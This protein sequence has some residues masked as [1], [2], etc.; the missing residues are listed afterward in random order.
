MTD[1]TEHQSDGVPVRVPV[2]LGDGRYR[3][4]LTP[5]G[6]GT[7][8][9]DDYLLT[10]WADDPCLDEHGL[11]LVIRALDGGRPWSACGTPMAVS[12]RVTVVPDGVQLDSAEGALEA[13]VTVRVFDCAEQRTLRLR[14]RGTTPLVLEVTA[15]CDVVLNPPDAQE[16]HPAFSKL[17]VQTAWDAQ[18]QGLVALRRPRQNGEQHPALAL[19]LQGAPI[20]SYE[21]DRARWLGRGRSAAQAQGLWAALSNTTGSVLDPV[22]ALRVRIS[23]P[24]QGEAVL[25]ATLGAADTRADLSAALRAEGPIASARAA[26]ADTLPPVLQGRITGTLAARAVAGAGAPGSTPVGAGSVTRPVNGYG[27]FVQSGEYR[28]VLTRTADGTLDLPPMPWTNVLANEQDFGVLVSE[29]GALTTF[30]GNSRL[31]RLTPWRNDPLVDPHDEAFFLRDEDSGAY[32]SLLPGPAPGAAAYE[33]RHG[34]GYTTYRHESLGLQIEATVYVPMDAPVRVL[35]VQLSNSS[36]GPRRLALYQM[37]TLV[38][39]G[40][41]TETRAAI[42]V[43]IDP[44][45]A[46]VLATNAMAG[47]FAGRVLFSTMVGVTISDASIDR[48]VVLGC[49]GSR[50]APAAVVLGGPLAVGQ[51]GEAMAAQRALVTIGPGET[52]ECAML[53]GEVASLAALDALRLRFCRVGVAAGL[54]AV[55]QYWSQLLSATRI[56]TPVPALDQVMNGWLGYQTLVCRLWARSAYYQSGGAYGFRDQLQDA[57]SFALAHPTLLRAQILRNAAHQFEAGDVLHWWHPP[58]S[59]GIRTRFADDLLWL[60]HLTA[61]YLASTGDLAVLDELVGFRAGPTLAADEDERYFASALAPTTATVYEHCVRALRRAMTTGRHGLPLFGCGDWN[62]GMNR[63]GRLGRGESTWMGF[64]L[65]ATMD[66]FAPYAKA[67]GDVALLDEMAAYR[68]PLVV[69]LNEAGW[70][71]GWY[72]RG[73]YDSGAPLG[74]KESDECQIDALAQAWAVISGVAS[75]ERTTLA[76]DALLAQLVSFDEGLVRLLAPPFVNTPE[77]PG[78]IKG[79]VAGVRE[80]G[81]Q[82]THAALWAAKALLLAG[83][84]DEGARLLTL[85]SPVSHAE[86]PA[87]V[88]RYQVEPYVIAADIYG[89]APHVGRGG[90]TWY[91]GSAGWMVRVTLENLLG[92]MVE[93]GQ[94]LVIAP[95]IPDTWPG[96]TVVLRR[97]EG[98][99][100]TIRVVTEGGASIVQAATL[101]GVAVQ[102]EPGRVVVPLCGDGAAHTIEVR[103]GAGAAQGS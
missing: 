19:C 83:R 73:Y 80:N 92:V 88:A 12:R 49:P 6:S 48:R 91:T 95:C 44:A 53:L 68:A 13:R 45:R 50:A 5:T 31:H 21:T 78:Y 67:R 100:Y 87:A 97:E 20:V 46:C 42:A 76:L 34:F 57:S 26:D 22:L 81:G 32:A 59:V 98:T 71:G 29:K 23:L 43:T 30:N 103:L 79:Y 65:I 2:I 3:A 28:I 72:R 93:Q 58:T 18:H 24:A 101:D 75:P 40:T 86:T 84:R 14:N 27:E 39:G 60:P 4:L 89:V 56:T 99:M 16:G 47:P 90:W 74:S 51:A 96:Y 8:V 41:P 66:A 102:T 63:V 62:D 82:Y 7:A 9:F 1:V 77:D 61:H 33:V 55:R 17:F 25:V 38:Q 11:A 15:V 54:T 37:A 64:F 36:A 85:L 70:D 69:A 35:S 10:G 52:L 94:R